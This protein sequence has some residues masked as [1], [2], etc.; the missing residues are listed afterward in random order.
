MFRRQTFGKTIFSE[1][2]K[3]IS[4]FQ[5]FFLEISSFLLCLKNKN[6]FSG[7]RK[8]IFPGNTRKI[9]F[10]HDLFRT[11]AKRNMIFRAVNGASVLKG[12]FSETTYLC[13]LTYQI[14]SFKHN[15]NQFQTCANFNPPPQSELPKK[16]HPDQD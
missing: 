2:L 10:Q 3:K 16:F 6:I 12:I 4:Y 7:K 1:H 15:S 8:I 14:S 11:F 9:M 13:L 5:V